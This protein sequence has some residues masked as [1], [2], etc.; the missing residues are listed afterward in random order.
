MGRLDDPDEVK[1]QYMDSSNLDARV[2]I[3]ELF[4]RDAVPWLSWSHDRLALRPGE[5]V[6][7][8]GCG[9]GDIWRFNTDR[10]PEGVHVT[11]ADQ[12]PGML[13]EARDR[14]SDCKLQTRFDVAD[15]ESLPYRDDA[16]DLVISNHVLY[17]VPDRLAALRELKR[18][19]R[20]SGRC[21]IS[22]N[23]WTHLIELR[24]LVARFR[25][26]PP[27]VASAVS[28]TSSTPNVPL[29]SWPPYS[30]LCAQCVATMLWTCQMRTCSSTT[31]IQ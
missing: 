5:R 2:R 24:E 8:V 31:S 12:S 6:L 9:R 16:F 23:D 7:D 25:V 10:L 14:L 19:V 27:C 21:I 17:H 20:S 15:I 26:P 4:S 22:T 3:Y 11:L 29:K 13:N 1:T 30:G 28:G 18:V